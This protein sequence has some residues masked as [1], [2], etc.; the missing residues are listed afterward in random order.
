[1]S[2]DLN[3]PALPQPLQ[4]IFVLNIPLMPQMSL[5]GADVMGEF[6]CEGVAAS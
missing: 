4:D 1:V 2:V 6:R 5:K 3:N